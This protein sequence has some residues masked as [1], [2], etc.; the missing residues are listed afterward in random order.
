MRRLHELVLLIA[1]TAAIALLCWRF[2]FSEVGAAFARVQLGY[3]GAYMALA[4]VVVIGYSV[5]WY[6]VARALGPAPGLGRFVAARLA[7]DAVGAV[8]PTGRLSGDPLRAALLYADGMGGPRASAGVAIDRV[9]ELAGNMLCVVAYV[10]VFS[11]AHTFGTVG[12][13]PVM[14][15]G[16]MLALLLMLAVAV[17]MLR[18]GRRPVS[19]LCGA[20]LQARFPRLRAGVA[21]LRETEADLIRFFR[22][23]PMTFI[24]GLLGSLLVEGLLI[25]EFYCLLT[26]FGTTLDL[27]T[28]LMAIMATGLARVVPI[29]AGLGVL[30]ASEVSLLAFASGRPEVGFLIGLVIRLHETLWTAAGFAVLSAQGVPKLRLRWLASAGR[31]AG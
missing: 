4:A 17:E 9:M 18:R 19:P 10:A 12:R 8:L 27:P 24:W 3:V 7:G 5:R 1:G 14:L 26:G 22:D 30:E 20:A 2:G 16:A 25:G 31:A 29:P 15:A 11:L 21:A 28:L 23:H 13:A 6:A